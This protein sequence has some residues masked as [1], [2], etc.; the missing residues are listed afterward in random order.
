L[1]KEDSMHILV[2]ML[3]LYWTWIKTKHL[4]ETV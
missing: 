4:N 1:L 2:A 3:L